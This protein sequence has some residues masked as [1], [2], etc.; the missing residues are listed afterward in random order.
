MGQ[1]TATRQGRDPERLRRQLRA[2]IRKRKDQQRARRAGQTPG[3]E[4]AEAPAPGGD[5][6][7]GAGGDG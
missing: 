7:D 4:S 2:N 1:D 5:D 6:S 3:A